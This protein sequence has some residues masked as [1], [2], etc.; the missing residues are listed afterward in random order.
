MMTYNSKKIKNTGLNVVYNLFRYI[1]LIASSYLLLYPFI[2]M[3]VGSFKQVGDFLDPSV[4]WI[5]KHLTFENITVSLNVL[6]YGKSIL[7]TLL[8]GMIPAALQ[9][10]TSA[11]AAYGLSRFSFKGRSVIMALRCLNLLD[12]DALTFIQVCTSL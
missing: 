3:I 10:C 5:P 6:E 9:F 4:N 2:Y 12:Q 1:V 11:L 7:R 8:Y